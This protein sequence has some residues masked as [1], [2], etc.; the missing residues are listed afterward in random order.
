MSGQVLYADDTMLMGEPRDD[1]EQIV[2]KPETDCDRMRLN[3]KVTKSKC[4]VF[5]KHRK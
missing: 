3:F 5:R 2:N 4:L 1:L